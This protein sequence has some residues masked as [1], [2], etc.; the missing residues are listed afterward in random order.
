MAVVNTLRL[1]FED[2][3]DEGYTFSVQHVYFQDMTQLRS[4]ISS[5]VPYFVD[6]SAQGIWAT[7][8]RLTGLRSAELI[9]VDT[10]PVPVE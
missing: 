7:P 3:T 5:G 10:R 8:S 2:G 6:A 1:V 9:V 4:N